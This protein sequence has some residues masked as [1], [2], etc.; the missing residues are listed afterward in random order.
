MA[1]KQAAVDT[2]NLYYANLAVTAELAGDYEEAAKNWR[3]ASMASS[4]ADSMI[5]YEEAAKRC[6]RRSKEISDRS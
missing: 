4:Q 1:K 5:L 2:R 3:S 6:E